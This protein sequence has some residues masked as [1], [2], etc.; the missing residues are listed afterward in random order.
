M[1]R[2]LFISWVKVGDIQKGKIFTTYGG[3]KFDLKWYSE[4]VE[5]R[6]PIVVGQVSSVFFDRRF[7][8]GFKAQVNKL[9][10]T[11]YQG[12]IFSSGITNI[13]SNNPSWL[14]HVINGGDP[15][16]YGGGWLNNN[17]LVSK[18][19]IDGFRHYI[20]TYYISNY[21]YNTD[22]GDVVVRVGGIEVDRNSISKT[23][24]SVTSFGWT[25]HFTG[26]TTI[27]LEGSNLSRIMYIFD[28][29]TSVWEQK[30]GILTI[31]AT[32]SNGVGY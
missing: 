1:R 21:N 26:E 17:Q 9:N 20:Y 16:A 2:C 18:G 25:P 12:L 13:N 11:L 15:S 4:N 6:N 27:S 7:T 23:A 3:E 10:G 32:D 8:C 5:W 22:V 19:Y 24:S 28:I 30:A 14:S 29:S 31:Y